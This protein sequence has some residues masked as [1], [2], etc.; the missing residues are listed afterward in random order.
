MYICPECG[1]PFKTDKAV[2]KHYLTC[3]KKEHPYIPPKS[4]LYT[5]SV[6]RKVNDEVADFFSALKKEK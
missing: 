4:V 5:Q 1:K 3:F 6:T 2:A